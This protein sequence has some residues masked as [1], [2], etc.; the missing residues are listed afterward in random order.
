MNR[1][2]HSM[3][4]RRARLAQL[5]QLPRPVAAL[6]LAAALLALPAGCFDSLLGAPC[7]AGYAMVGGACVAAEAPPDGSPPD[8][9]DPRPDADPTPDG[10][11]C[12]AP[13]EDCGGVCV[14]TS[15]SASDCGTCGHVCPSGICAESLCLG[16]LRGHIIAIGHDYQRQHL[17]MAHVLGNSIALGAHPDVGI[18]RWHGTAVQAAMDGTSLAIGHAMG[19][20]GRPWHSVPLPSVASPYAL[21]SSDVLLIEAQTGSGAAAEAMGAS[22]RGPIDGF[23]QRGGVV[24]VLE[25]AGGVSHR[26]ARG[27]GLFDVGAPIEA[28]GEQ[29]RVADGTDAIA[30]Q[31]VSPYL[32]EATSVVFPAAPPPAVIEAASGGTLVFHTT[33]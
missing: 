30:L 8:A 19:Q 31:V 3:S 23:L 25:G 17:T 27:A 2:G 20:L 29:A 26:F 33:R 1:T 14:D 12:A 11:I 21:D 4:P 13:L 6:G 28:T 32:A 10:T 18:S 5:A 16:A 9:G 24:I 7:A 15:S 22:W